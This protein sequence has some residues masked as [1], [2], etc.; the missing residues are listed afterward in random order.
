MPQNA[1]PDGSAWERPTRW[2]SQKTTTT[3]PR[4]PSAE[5]L[6]CSLPSTSPTPTPQAMHFRR[7]TAQIYHHYDLYCT[8]ITT[9]RASTRD[10][11]QPQPTEQ[12]E[13]RAP[14][15][16]PTTAADATGLAVPAGLA[17][18]FRATCSRPRNAPFRTY[19]THEERCSLRQ[20]GSLSACSLRVVK[21]RDFACPPSS[22]TCSTRWRVRRNP[23]PC[24]CLLHNLSTPAPPGR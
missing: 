12:C 10:I 11:R 7:K 1:D 4:P 8:D 24:G 18:A 15:C 13:R 19:S 9:I 5:L 6:F 22:P 14:S 16:A 2:A 3:T 23:P 17:A 21:L 20:S